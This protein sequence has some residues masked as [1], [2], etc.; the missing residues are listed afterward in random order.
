M[1][2]ILCAVIALALSATV[3]F[4]GCFSGGGSLE[5]NV[6]NTYESMTDEQWQEYKYILNNS[7]PDS[8]K[9]L[10]TAVNAL[11]LQ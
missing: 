5:V 11:H 1:K 6:N 8:G 9:S 10:Q 4:S 2:K 7:T 3:L